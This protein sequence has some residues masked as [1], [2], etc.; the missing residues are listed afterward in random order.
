MALSILGDSM[1]YAVLPAHAA[2]LGIPVAGVGVILSVNRWIR[3][4]TNF[5]AAGVFRRLGSR[6]GLLKE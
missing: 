4:A 1:L 3:L 2:S 5:G 6:R